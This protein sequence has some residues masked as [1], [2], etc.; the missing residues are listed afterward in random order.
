[1][2]PR[3]LKRSTWS[4]PQFWGK[5]RGRVVDNIDPL[6]RARLSV[7]VLEIS[8]AVTWALPALTEFDLARYVPPPV[9]MNVWVEFEH[10]DVARPIWTGFFWPAGD[11]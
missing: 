8:P 1:M 9:G 11:T 2:R 7:E 6:G 4:R 10:G 5:Y 3:T